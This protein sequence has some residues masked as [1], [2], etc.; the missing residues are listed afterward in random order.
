MLAKLHRALSVILILYGKA[1][2]CLYEEPQS[3]S[4]LYLEAEPLLS[5]DKISRPNKFSLCWSTRIRP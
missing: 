5:F 4:W 2:V 3:F 1:N